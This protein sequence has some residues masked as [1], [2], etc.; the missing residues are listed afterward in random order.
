MVSRIRKACFFS[1][2]LAAWIFSDSAMAARFSNQSLKGSYA[3]S[4]DG[5][6]TFIDKNPVALPAWFTGVV[7]VDGKGKITSFTGTFNIGA[8]I[9]VSHEG[10]GIY[11]VNSN[12]TA[13][14]TVNLKAEPISLPSSECP[15]NVIRV[16]S[17]MSKSN[18]VKFSLAIQ[19]TK[20]VYGSILSKTDPS[21]KPV[22]FGGSLTAFKQ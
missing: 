17:S 14:A 22:G 21:G 7:E 11:E 19:N 5:I 3:A 15:D 10:D 18:I 8:C 12:G 20:A 6:Y 16:I 9:V 13:I 2:I 1:L 4:I